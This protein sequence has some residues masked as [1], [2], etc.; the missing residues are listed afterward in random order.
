MSCRFFETDVGRNVA[1]VG[2]SHKHFSDS[3][4]LEISYKYGLQSNNAVTVL[5]AYKDANYLPPQSVGSFWSASVCQT[6]KT[7]IK[8]GPGL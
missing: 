6:L 2:T 8:M 4:Y 1:A 3:P 5:A 7:S